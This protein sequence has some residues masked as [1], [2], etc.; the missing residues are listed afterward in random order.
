MTRDLRVCFVGDSFVAGVGDTLCLGWAGRMA[1]R[2]FAGGQPLTWY[3]LGVRRETSTQILAR[4]EDECGRRL[5]DGTDPRVVL[6]LGVNDTTWEND[7]PRVAPDES[8]ANLAEI[9][10]RAAV[11][12]WPVL[13]VA[14][15]PVGDPGQNARTALLDERFAR[16]CRDASV[17]Y[18]PVHQPLRDS[19]VW[20]HEVRTG[21]GAHPGAGGYDALAELIAPHWQQWL[22]TSPLPA[23][24][25][26][27]A[28]I[29]QGARDQG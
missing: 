8:V 29:R 7:G 21:D 16:I 22:S 13:V 15:P 25:P 17:P 10:D 23:P 20:M 12:G 19:A 14:P 6:S 1:A 5:R 11:R 28:A 27:D 9:L 18:V 3:N 4:W 26:V 2:A 24:P